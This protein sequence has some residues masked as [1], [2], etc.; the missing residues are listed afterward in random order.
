LIP[1][2]PT[3]AIQRFLPALRPPALTE[4]ELKYVHTHT[5]LKPSAS[6]WPY[7]QQEKAALD[8]WKR[9]D[10]L[11]YLDLLRMEPHLLETLDFLKDQG[12]LRASA[13]AVQRP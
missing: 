6:F 11:P 13:P 1:L 8:F 10:I 12:I 2:N 4:E 5:S 9:I 7:A 3:Q